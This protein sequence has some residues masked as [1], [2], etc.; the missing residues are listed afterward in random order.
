MQILFS[1]DQPLFFSDGYRKQTIFFSWP[2][3]WSITI[4]LEGPLLFVIVFKVH[5]TVEHTMLA[6]VYI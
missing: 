2:Y 1:T 5:Y 6:S 4:M 3:I